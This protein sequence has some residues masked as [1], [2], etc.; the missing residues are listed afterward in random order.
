MK[1]K[2]IL[3]K[4]N[5]LRDNGV[6]VD[7]VVRCLRVNVMFYRKFMESFEI[8]FNVLSCSLHYLVP[9]VDTEGG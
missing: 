1:I 2:N 6:C 4:M 5:T 7:D 8:I 9:V 3:L